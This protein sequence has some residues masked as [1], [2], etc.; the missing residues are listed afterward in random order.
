MNDIL[1]ALCEAGFDLNVHL[2]AD[3]RRRLRVHL[4]A[5]DENLRLV[6]GCADQELVA[7]VAL[8]THDHWRWVLEA[9]DL[10]DT[11]LTAGMRIKDLLDGWGVVVWIDVPNLE[12]AIHLLVSIVVALFSL[13]KLEFGKREVVDVPFAI[14]SF[15]ASKALS[16]LIDVC[17]GT[18]VDVMLSN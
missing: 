3:G 1:D 14:R 17:G 13:E 9:Q 8:L 12:L 16:I 11:F 7:F 10:G 15:L 5:P 4:Q 18:Q 6:G 2:H